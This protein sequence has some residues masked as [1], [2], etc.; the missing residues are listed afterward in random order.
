M[1]TRIT[2]GHRTAR[3]LARKSKFLLTV[4]ASLLLSAPFLSAQNGS[5]I[6]AYDL[7]SPADLALSFD[8]NGSGAADHLIFYRPG[9]GVIYILANTNGTWTT[10]F[11]STQGIGGYDLKSP[12]DRIIAFDYSGK[13]YKDHLVCYRPGTGIV[14]ILA[15]SNGVFT[16]V[17]QGISGIGSFDMRS[18]ADRLL[19]YD[20]NGNGLSNYLVAYRPGTGVVHILQ[21]TNGNF[22]PVYQ[23][24]NGIGGFDLL[25][26][27]D[28]II[29]FDYYGIGVADHLV[30]YRPGSG[31]IFVLRNA[32]GFFYQE[33]AS[34]TGLGS[35]D[36]ASP[37]DVLLPIDYN[38]SGNLD[39]ILAYRPGTGVAYILGLSYFQFTTVF[40]SS[41]GI[42]DY[43]LMSTTDR[44][45]TYDYNGLG[46]QTNLVLYRPGT[47]AIAVMANTNGTFSSLYQ[48]F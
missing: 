43:D 13:G 4:F 28:R 27:S 23:G 10:V 44:I 48:S 34:M 7:K 11:S 31:V 5:G 14:Q 38:G 40:Q 42:G 17:Y 36:L 16:P 1:L 20:F 9:T 19:A 22:V 35:Y 41:H 46:V 8:Y 24:S 30:A 21:N 39:H 45:T 29:A 25:S 33:S 47:G 15:N 37:T 12:A 3:S 6:G 18:T 32:N 2:E 26:T